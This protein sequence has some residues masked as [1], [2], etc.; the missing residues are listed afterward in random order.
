MKKYKC[1]DMNTDLYDKNRCVEIA[2]EI[3]DKKEIVHMNCSQLS[4][5][6]YAHAYVYYNFDI[7]PKWLRESKLGK[8]MY[9]ISENG[10]DLEDGGDTLLR[11]IFYL[12]VWIAPK[13]KHL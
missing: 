8:S 2:R 4:K 5:E 11:R 3:I 12:L 7:A 13:F 9:I 6:I 10:V 1:I